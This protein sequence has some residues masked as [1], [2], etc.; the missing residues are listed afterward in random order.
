MQ[1]IAHE[2]ELEAIASKQLAGF[3]VT[4]L[5]LGVALEQRFLQL[6]VQLCYSYN[7]K[8]YNMLS[9]GHDPRQGNSAI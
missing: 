2:D 3:D 8:R 4:R 1:A 7:I 6:L 9:K 5:H